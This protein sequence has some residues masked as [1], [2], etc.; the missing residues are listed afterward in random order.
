M[1][2]RKLAIPHPMILTEDEV[3][4]EVSRVL[5]AEEESKRG[6]SRD[7]SGRILFSKEQ[8]EQR[9]AY[10]TNKQTIIEDRI[11]VAVGLKKE[12]LEQRLEN[13]KVVIQQ[14]KKELK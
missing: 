7:Q 4:N 8:L 5:R 9:L 1:P 3:M 14:I 10:F 2:K 12:I 11:K 6:I 13:L